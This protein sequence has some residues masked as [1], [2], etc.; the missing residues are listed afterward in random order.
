M[1]PWNNRNRNRHFHTVV[2]NEMK[3]K[4]LKIIKTKLK[5][6]SLGTYEINQIS[7][8]MSNKQSW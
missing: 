8:F 4:K 1:I 6:H 5:S 3:K 2:G 7:K